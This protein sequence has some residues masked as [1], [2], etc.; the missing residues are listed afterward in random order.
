VFLALK[1]DHFDGCYPLNRLV[2]MLLVDYVSYRHPSRSPLYAHVALKAVHVPPGSSG[3]GGPVTAVVASPTTCDMT[4]KDIANWT[5]K[6]YG[7]ELDG[8]VVRHGI[9]TST[10]SVKS[11]KLRQQPVPA[12]LP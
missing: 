10:L 5:G 4:A 12:H 9:D 2:A 11:A 1:S 7:I 6:L 3:W 8:I